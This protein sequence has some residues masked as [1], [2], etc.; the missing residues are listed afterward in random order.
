VF[1]KII[2]NLQIYVPPRP[3]LTGEA[4]DVDRLDYLLLAT[5]TAAGWTLGMLAFAVL[6]FRRRDFL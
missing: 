1:G 4:A 3:L 2:P 5:G 6:I